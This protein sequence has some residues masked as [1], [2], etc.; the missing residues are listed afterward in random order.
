MK[1]IRKIDQSRNSVINADCIHHN[2]QERQV[3]FESLKPLLIELTICEA[4]LLIFALKIRGRVCSKALSRYQPIRGNDMS[5]KLTVQ[6]YY[7]LVDMV[8]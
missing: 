2:E 8:V 4:G 6:F 5:F 1:T 7:T 3:L